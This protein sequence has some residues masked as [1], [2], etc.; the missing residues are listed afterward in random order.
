MVMMM[1]LLMR[2]MMMITQC[3]GLWM[4]MAHATFDTLVRVVY[5]EVSTW[6][7]KSW[8]AKDGT[9]DLVQRAVVISP[10]HQGL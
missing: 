1:L 2:M 5:N 4:W 7:R 9:V 6:P 8:K 10:R 3:V